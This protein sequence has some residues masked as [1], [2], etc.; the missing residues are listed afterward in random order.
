MSDL[1]VRII[2]GHTGTGGHEIDAA[3]IAQ[4]ARKYFNSLTLK[5]TKQ[6]NAIRHFVFPYRCARKPVKE[7]AAYSRSGRL[8]NRFPV[9]ANTASATAGAIG[10]TPGSPMPSGGMALRI[11]MVSTCGARSARN[12]W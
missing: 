6:A 3:S 1:L 8:R 9:N 7:R 11:T 12:T 5:A 10:G 4:L 2:T